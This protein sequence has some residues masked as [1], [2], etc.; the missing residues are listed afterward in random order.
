MKTILIIVLM[1]VPA[2][3]NAETFGLGPVETVYSPAVAGQTFGLSAQDSSFCVVMPDGTKQCFASEAAYRLFTATP[4]RT[5][6]AAVVNR[7]AT[8]TQQLVAVPCPECPSGVRYTVQSVAGTIVE[9]TT[10]IA[11]PIVRAAPVR[12]LVG[13]IQ[14]RRANRSGRIAGFFQRLSSRFGQSAFRIR[15]SCY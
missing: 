13:N 11:A 1:F 10:D 3:A 12:S 4:I 7:A 14:A 5:T 9:A 6:T 8:V 15:S 2:I